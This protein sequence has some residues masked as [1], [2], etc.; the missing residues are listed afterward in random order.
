MTKIDEKREKKNASAEID[1]VCYWEEMAKNTIE[2]T[3]RD[4]FYRK[5]VSSDR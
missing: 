3:R 1:C 5:H 2:S 4:G